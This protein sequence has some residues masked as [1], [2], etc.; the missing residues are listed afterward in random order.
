M[1]RDVSFD[2]PR[3]AISPIVVTE[4]GMLRDVR[5]DIPPKA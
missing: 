5:D 3:K 2:I 1:L 4:L